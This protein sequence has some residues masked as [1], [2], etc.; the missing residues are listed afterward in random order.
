VR[1]R[2]R[3]VKVHTKDHEEVSGIYL[4]HYAKMA[5]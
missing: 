4:Q 2:G 5:D 3:E 1:E